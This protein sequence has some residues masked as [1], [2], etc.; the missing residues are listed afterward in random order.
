MNPILQKDIL[1][2]FRLKR[3]AALHVAFIL[4]L[5]LG[6]LACW[7]Q[8][9]VVSIANTAQDDLLFTL[10]VGQLVLLHIFIPGGAA[11][12]IAGEW[13]AD[14]FE[15]LYASR[16][17]INQI[18]IGKI[19]GI[20]A[21]P[22]LLVATSLPFLGLLACRGITDVGL[23]LK[24]YGLLCV[25]ALYLSILSLVVS[26]CCR[27]VS[28]A[29]VASYA[30]TFIL[31]VVP[32][33][34]AAI[35]LETSSGAVAFLLHYSRSLSPLSAAM[36]LLRPSLGD[37]D[38]RLHHLYSLWPVF[39]V[40][41][42]ATS[43]AGIVFVRIRL[44]QNG[45]ALDKPQARQ[46][47]SPLPAW[48]RILFLSPSVSTARTVGSSNPL[49]ANE[50]R[51][52]PVCSGRWGVRISYVSLVASLSLSLISLYAGTGDPGLLNYVVLVVAAFSVGVIALIS[53][54]LTSPSLSSEIES[55]TFE[56]LRMTPLRPG[57]YFSG[58]LL[59]SLTSAALPMLA[60][61]PAYAAICYMDPGY[62][63]YF[64]RLLPILICAGVLC[65]MVGFACSAW[66]A[67]SARATVVS[68]AICVSLF[69]LP[70]FCE[71]I[72]RGR[73]SATAIEG[74]SIPSPLSAAVHLLDRSSSA[75]PLPSLWGNHLIA[76][77]AAVLLVAGV[78]WFRLA[79][80]LESK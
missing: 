49:F 11:V 16:L 37:F 29:L 27:Q 50:A 3:A 59:S 14:T 79:R 44:S 73:L 45:T 52:N 25:A 5:G 75:M 47:T 42:F 48:R 74:L 17:S 51:I 26:A 38:G 1:Q 34:P 33:V 36:A 18:L 20:L 63:P 23:V 67:N 70:P 6:I 77:S 62:I 19:G 68:Y 76:M 41:S 4:V 31:C 32:F 61:L 66:C 28:T 12:A 39:L 69:F 78:A 64:A 30:A 21:F 43:A 54:A 60:L 80:L 24:S 56:L 13:E 65:C 58:K 46:S 55:G 7:P 35:L 57:Q 8:G 72:S 2:T 9:G 22:L 15:M 71:L 10:I 53:P 40:A